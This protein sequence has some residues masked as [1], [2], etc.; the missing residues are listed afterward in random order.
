M[1]GGSRSSGGGGGCYITTAICEEYGKPDDCYELT[2]FR[3][4]RD[5]WLI[6]QP[7]G[8]ELIDRYYKTAPA[9]VELI[10]NQKNRTEIYRHLNDNYLAKCLG[11]IEV[12]EN[13]KLQG[14]VC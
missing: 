7:D 12:G 5:N 14:L 11:Y 3:G 8:K 6:N 13:E 10:N 9:V 4:F 1:G 2:A